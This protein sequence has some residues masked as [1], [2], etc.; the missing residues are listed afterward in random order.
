MTF[1]RCFKP[2]G[3]LDNPSLII[4]SDASLNAYGA[5][6]YIVFQL[7]SGA[8]EAN[9]IGAKNKIAP[10]RQQTM[11]RLEL[12][13]AVLACRLRETIIQELDWKFKSI[14]HV[15]DS[16]IVCSQIQKDSYDFKTFVATRVSEIQSKTNGRDWYWIEGKLNPADLLTRPC[17]P[18]ILNS[19]SLWQSGPEF[20]SLPFEL[21]PI[22]QEYA[23]E[24][25]DKVASLTYVSAEVKFTLMDFDLNRYSNYYKLL[26]V[27]C[28]VLCVYKHKSL[29]G[30]SKEP[31][32]RD[33]CEVELLW[34]RYVQNNLIDWKVRYT[35]LGPFIK[36]GI[37]YVGARISK[38]LKDN[39][40]QDN[41]ILLPRDHPFTRLYIT[42]LH[43]QSH[44][45]VETILA[46]LQTK[47]WV[48]AARKI[49]KNI[50]DKCVLCKK[51]N[52]KIDH[53]IMGQRL[54][55][56]MKP[57]PPF[58]HCAVDLY[59]PFTIKDTVKRRVTAKCFGVIFTCFVTRAVYLD[60]TEGYS[61][62]DFLN[63]FHRFVC[64][65][66]YPATIHSDNG[67]QL[68]AANKELRNIAKQLNLNKIIDFGTSKGVQWSFN[69]SSDSPWYNASCESLIRLVKTGLVKSIGESILTFS[70][71]QTV[72][73]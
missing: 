3:A 45:G 72:I 64:I 30:M 55:K 38:W 25:P 29:F 47:F 4:F 59:G 60:L 34:I 68:V 43:Y 7:S 27:T 49:I 15:V 6:A 61:T 16:M 5:V 21:W 57:S 18:I 71:L 22:S 35:R 51:L 31:T 70:E 52:M 23:L 24:L 10:T 69:K 36:D 58:H 40:N 44:E 17:K 66:G 9:L 33:I 46:K 63:T 1:K 13:G 50:K 54:D 62:N 41:F 20:L 28:R 37:I 12:C 73:F 11:P 19:N 48:P 2:V 14:I 8:Y 65:R 39:Y 42:H 56:Q 32:P 67:T 53:Q 26:R